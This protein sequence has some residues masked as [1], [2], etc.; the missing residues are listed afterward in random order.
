MCLYKCYQSTGDNYVTAIAETYFSC[1]GQTCLCDEQYN[2]QIAFQHFSQLR[3]RVFYG[4]S[5]KDSS[6]LRALQSNTSSLFAPRFHSRYSSKNTRNVA[7]AMRVFG[8]YFRRFRKSET[9]CKLSQ[10]Y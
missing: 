6:Y 7:A 1:L 8:A 2:L 9:S 10:R 3:R 4:N 5:Q